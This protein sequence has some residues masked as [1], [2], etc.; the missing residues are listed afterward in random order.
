MSEH[1]E[2]HVRNINPRFLNY[3]KKITVTIHQRNL[4]VLATEIF[5]A[6]NDLSSELMKDVFELKSSPLA[7]AQK[8][9]TLY[10]EMSKLP[11]T[12]VSHSGI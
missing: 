9:T 5:K 3:Y 11:I 6:K 8:E 2:V 1:L 12:V 7:Y 4:Q 10:A